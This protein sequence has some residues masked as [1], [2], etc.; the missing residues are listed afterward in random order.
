MAQK[1]MFDRD[2]I[3]QDAF[4]E[5]PADSKALY[6]LLGMEADDEGFVS[7]KK[8]M[9]LYGIHTDDS[10]KLLIAKNFVIPFESGV[11]VITDWNRN[12]YLNATRKRPTIYQEERIHVYVDEI[13]L[14]YACLTDVK[15]MFN[16]CLTRGE[17]NRREESR[18]LDSNESLCPGKSGTNKKGGQK[19]KYD[20][21]S[22]EMK[23]ANFM[24]AE[25]LKHKPD[26]IMRGS[27][28]SWCDTFRLMLERDKREPREICAVIR[29]CQNDSF[30]RGNVLSPDKLRKQY[31]ALAIRREEGKKKHE[32][33][34]RV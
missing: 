16:R 17:E 6:F 29:Y 20:D 4:L 7:A 34:D 14:K 24:Q 10:I 32:Q 33:Q 11:V 1:R 2:I 22:N 21:D 15:P 8:V 9:R 19:K 28:N 23:L 26:W 3:T 25:I 13:S 31:D 30:W 18:R 5:L 27:I 12:N